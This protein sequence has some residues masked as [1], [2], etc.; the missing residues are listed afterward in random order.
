MSREVE[1]IHRGSTLRE[2]AGFLV[3]RGF[4]TPELDVLDP[5][6]LLDE[7][8]PTE[9]AP[10]EAEGA[11]DHPHRGF[12]TVTYLISGDMEHHDSHGNRGRLAPGGV[13]WMTA[14]AGVIHS[15]MPTAEFQRSG[16]LMHGFQIWVNLPRSRKMDPPRY[17]E[18][19]SVDP[20][21]IAPNVMAK[22]ISGSIGDARGVAETVAPVTIA[23]LELGAGSSVEIPVDPGSTV[24]LWVFD[25]EID[26][27][28]RRVKQ[29]ELA[30]YSREGDS[31]ALSAAGS[32]ANCML[33]TGRP[34][35]EPVAR[36]GPFVMNYRAEIVQAMED[37]QSGRFGQIPPEIR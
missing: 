27:T 28:G 30:L 8:G 7:M 20:T 33:L 11:P 6:L 32:A 17:Q 14:G 24:A 10:G 26:S 1:Q 29:Y 9:Y 22:I 2:G 19:A 18:I 12:E 16:G 5:F 35:K 15:E 23:H 4:P 21:T 25:G 37:F 31:I 13:Q 36:Y 3:H 34:L